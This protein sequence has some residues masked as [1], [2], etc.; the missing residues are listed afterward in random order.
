MCGRFTLQITK[1]M[2]AEIFG[3]LVIQDF[4]PRYNI[5]P[6]QQVAVVRIST[7]GSRHLD[8]LKW[9]LIPSWSK[10]PSI[11]SKMINARSETVD[12]KPSLRSAFKH[13]RCIIP[14]SGFY[15]WQEVGGKKH[16]LYVKLKGQHVMLFAGLWEHWKPEEGDVIESCTI[17]TTTNNELIKPLHDRMP[18]ILD[19]R[20]KD[21]WLDPHVSDTEQLKSLFKPYP[22]EMMDMYRVSNMVNSPKNDNPDCI[23]PLDSWY[24][25]TCGAAT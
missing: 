7:D 10:D 19:T 15:E 5:A 25:E 24:M 20:D 4:K 17:L 1:E 12:T 11:G 9:G 22:S 8:L 21:L 3:N 2:L 14:A 6:T 18:V 16:P 13:R 23:K